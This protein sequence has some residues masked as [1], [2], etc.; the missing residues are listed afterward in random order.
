MVKLHVLKL[1]E[2]PIV[3]GNNYNRFYMLWLLQ[4]DGPPKDSLEAGWQ[5]IDSG[6]V[7]FFPELQ[8]GAGEFEGLRFAGELDHNNAIPLLLA[9]VESVE[10]PPEIAAM[11][12]QNNPLTL[13]RLYEQPLEEVLGMQS[14]GLTLE[15]LYG[16]SEVVEEFWAKPDIKRNANEN[17]DEWMIPL[18]ACSLVRTKHYG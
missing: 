6:D 8:T 1:H 7:L 4:N 14:G 5:G 17:Q 9:G 12:D 16:G 3:D 13:R 2:S 10:F 15:D 18:S 11:A